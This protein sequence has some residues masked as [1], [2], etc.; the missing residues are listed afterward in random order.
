MEPSAQS[1]E[2]S[3]YQVFLCKRGRFHVYNSERLQSQSLSFTPNE[4]ILTNQL[5]AQP[6][7]EVF[8]YGESEYFDVQRFNMPPAGSADLSG[9]KRIEGARLSMDG[10]L[11]H[12]DPALVCDTY[13][14]ITDGLEGCD[15]IIDPTILKAL[16]A[17][18]QFKL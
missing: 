4:R 10:K 2:V 6:S 13:Q 18:K 17:M 1:T 15:A 8:A 12:G 11:L 14:Q 9:F 16:Q 5:D 3:E 7:V